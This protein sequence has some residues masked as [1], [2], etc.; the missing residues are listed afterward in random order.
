MNGFLID[1][2]NINEMANKINLLIRDENLRCEFS[3][4]ATINIYKFEKKQIIEKWFN[5]IEKV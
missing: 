5:L 1:N 2:G 3:N 4:N